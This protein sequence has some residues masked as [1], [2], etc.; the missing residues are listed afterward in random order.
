VSLYCEY[1]FSGNFLTKLTVLDAGSLS[2][3]F[4]HREVRIAT[5]LR[6]EQRSMHVPRMVR[7]ALAP[8]RLTSITQQPASYSYGPCHP[9]RLGDMVPIHQSLGLIG[10]VDLRAVL[11]I[12]DSSNRLLQ[13]FIVALGVLRYTD[14]VVYFTVAFQD[15]AHPEEVEIA[16]SLGT[17]FEHSELLSRQGTVQRLVELYERRPAVFSM[18]RHV[19]KGDGAIEVGDSR[20]VKG[21]SISVLVVERKFLQHPIYD[22]SIGI[23]LHR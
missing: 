13:P 6:A 2:V 16:R 5:S 22:V 10:D 21:L 11:W 3:K 17:V 4:E 19:F 1:L 23:M 15:L 9:E 12:M 20:L 14:T 8:L 18:P 7:Q